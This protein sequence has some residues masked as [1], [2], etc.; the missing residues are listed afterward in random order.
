[1][2]ISMT[3][4]EK[5]WYIYEYARIHKHICTCRIA[6]LSLLKILIMLISQYKLG[7]FYKMMVMIND[8]GIS[9]V[10]LPF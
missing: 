8:V 3:K 10:C 2:E 5:H 4:Y 7:F 9:F 6:N 1:M